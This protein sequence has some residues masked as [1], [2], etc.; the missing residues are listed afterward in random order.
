MSIDSS[1]KRRLTEASLEVLSKNRRAKDGFQYT[2]PSPTAYPY[3]WLWDSCFHAIVLSHLS[4]ADAK[5]ELLSLVSKQFD[6]G[7]IPHMIYWEKGEVINFKWGKEHTSSITQPPMIALA[8]WEIYG[9][10]KD[11]EFLKKLYPHLYHFYNYILNERD[12]RRH[13]L[14]SIINPD[15]SGEDNSPRF[16][17][18]L[19]LPTKQTIKESLESRLEL[20]EK[21]KSCDFDAPFCMKHFFW[22]KD[23]PFNAILCENLSVLSKI[24]DELAFKEDSI[25]YAEES[26]H[27][28]RAMRELMMEDGLFWPTYGENYVKTKVKT[29]ALFAPMFAGIPTADEAKKLVSGFLDNPSEFKTPYIVPSVSKSDPAYDPA[30]FW[31]GS[32]WIAVNWFVRRGLLRYGMKEQAARV[33]DSTVAL[34]DKSGFREYFH[35]DTGAGLGAENFTWGTLVVDMMNDDD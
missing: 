34:L 29:W 10:D 16:D 2:V 24:A 5:K 3:Q 12:P 14:A 15:E 18:P 6:N 28:S 7:M 22:A 8:A 27:V 4:P 26:L 21:L 20:V 17:T 19:G 30:G 9:K 13:H 25:R 35:P 11:K 32:V 33:L 31:R 23:V 1:S